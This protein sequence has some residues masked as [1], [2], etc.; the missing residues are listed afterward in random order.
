[1]SLSIFP[2]SESFFNN[3]FLA[4]ESVDDESFKMLEHILSEIPILVSMA[5]FRS[6]VLN[7]G[8]FINV[9]KRGYNIER[10]DSSLTKSSSV[11]LHFTFLPSS[12][13]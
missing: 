13:K 8:F 4:F 12:M 6:R 3:L 10:S 5:S 2:S 7:A 1:M 11:I 9:I